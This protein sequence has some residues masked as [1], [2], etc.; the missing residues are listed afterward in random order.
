[1][2]TIIGMICK[3]GLVLAA[4]KRATADFVVDKRA[5]KINIIND[6]M[7]TLQ[8]GVVSDCQ[9]FTKL[10]RAEIRIKDLQ[11][12]RLTTAQ[13]AAS[14][15]AGIVY[16]NVRRPAMFQSI[17][18]FLFGGRD[19]LG[20][21]LFSLGIDGSVIKSDDYVA[22]G[23]GSVFALGVLESSYKKH[24]SLAEGTKVAVA[25][26]NAAVQRDMGSGNGIDVVT[27]TERGIEKTVEKELVA[28]LD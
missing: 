6:R 10:L 11:T 22:S 1:M 28:R 23:S 14:L 4:D 5:K 3:D 12:D 25:A 27:I 8:T 19:Q 16:D 15:L 2:T 13:E 7:A 9:L 17:A 21:H 24:M 26:V 18:G 20:Y